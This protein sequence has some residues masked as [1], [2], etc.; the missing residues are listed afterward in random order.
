MVVHKKR[1]NERGPYVS[2]EWSCG[3][4]RNKSLMTLIFGRMVMD[5]KYMELVEA[6]GSTRKWLK[7]DQTIRNLPSGN[8]GIP[9]V[10]I[11][12]GLTGLKKIR[13]CIS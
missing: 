4:K 8:L 2:V 12:L 3:H 10:V 5:C 6:G 11:Q 9:L 7:F 1:I 13:S